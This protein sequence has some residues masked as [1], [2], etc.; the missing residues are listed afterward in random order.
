MQIF[1]LHGVSHVSD[2][3]L[4]DFY[5]FSFVLVMAMTILG[6]KTKCETETK[7]KR[8]PT[9]LTEVL[10]FPISDWLDCHIIFV[11]YILEINLLN[12]A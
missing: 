7:V 9:C 5:Y 11:N 10:L 1:V 3:V 6:V 4:S 12:I 8:W 2:P